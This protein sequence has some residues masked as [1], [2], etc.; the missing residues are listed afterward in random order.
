MKKIAIVFKDE[1]LPI[2]YSL[3]A[4]TRQNSIQKMIKFLIKNY[5]EKERIIISCLADIPIK[6]KSELK[7]LHANRV[8]P[9][10]D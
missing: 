7:N 3:M 4:E 8:P 2:I 5:W 9:K 6:D 10:T 1:E